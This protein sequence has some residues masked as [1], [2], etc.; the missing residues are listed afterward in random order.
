MAQEDT[1]HISFGQ[2]QFIFN[3]VSETW[4]DFSAEEAQSVFNETWAKLSSTQLQSEEKKTKDE[5]SRRKTRRK[6]TRRGHKKKKRT[7]KESGQE[8]RS[9]FVVPESHGT[10]KVKTDTVA[11]KAPVDGRKPTCSGADEGTASGGVQPAAPAEC[12]KPTRFQRNN[13]VK[14]SGVPHIIW[15]KNL[16]AWRVQIA[17]LYSRSFPVKRFLVPGRSELEADAAA[18]EAAKACRT[19]LVQQGFLSE[20]KPWDPNF[21]SEMPGVVWHKQTQKWHVRICRKGSKK[22][23]HGGSFTEKAAAEAKALELREQHGLQRKGKAGR[24]GTPRRPSGAACLHPQGPIPW[25]E[26]EPR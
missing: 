18:L 2:F 24:A 15:D 20:P 21:K 11:G 3:A 8:P 25:G 6:R 16:V 19:E 13:L 17:G 14:Q 23:I 22:K 5:E 7:L 4:N 10:E 26:V 12:P 9:P 1:S